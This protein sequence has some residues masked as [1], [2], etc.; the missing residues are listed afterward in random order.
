[1]RFEDLN[2]LDVEN[3]L[4]T[5]DRL[6]LVTGACEQHGYL[7]LLTDAKIPLAFADAASQQTGVLVGPALNFGISP[8]FTTYPGTITLRAQTYLAVINDLVRA[9]HGSGF[10]RILFVNGHGGND[11]ARGVLAELVNELPGLQVSWYSWWLSPGTAAVAKAAGLSPY[12][13]SWSE[14]FAFCRVAD[15]PPGEKPPA[16]STRILSA[17]ETKALAGDGVF[18]G[19]YSANDAVMQQLFEACV[20]EVVERLKFE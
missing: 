8:Y 5:D 16:L 19:A 10:R 2:W 12:H 1:M 20:G 7:S 3:Y 13:A 4:K 15:L 17:A 9:L 11:P 6:M 18:G 14:A